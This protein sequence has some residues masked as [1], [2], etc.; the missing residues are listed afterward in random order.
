MSK[1][2]KELK[3]LQREWYKKL[4]DDGFEDIEYMDEDMEPKTILKRDT[5]KHALQIKDKYTQVQSHYT[6]A[7]QLL[8]TTFIPNDAI[9]IWKQYTEGTPYRAIAKNLRVSYAYVCGV[10][11]KTK[12]VLI[13][14]I[15]TENKAKH[16]DNRSKRTAKR[17]FS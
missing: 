3:Q 13:E 4:A 14:Y 17:N 7:R 8:H 10:I 2:N 6:S 16:E 11:N 15:K 9:E 1:K 12:V 5:Y